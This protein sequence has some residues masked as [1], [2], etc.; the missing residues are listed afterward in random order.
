[1]ADTDIRRQRSRELLIDALLE[2]METNH[3]GDITVSQVA[4]KA[5]V[6][7]STFYAQFSDMKVFVASITDGVLVQLR[8][9]TNPVEK[10]LKYGDDTSSKYFV[11]YFEFIAEHK[12]FFS[13]MLGPNGSPSFR[14]K[15]VDSAVLVYESVFRYVPTERMP[16]ERDILINYIANA[17]VGIT[18]QWLR[19]GMRLSADYMARSLTTIIFSGMLGGLGMDEL[20]TLPS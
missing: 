3:L 17:N 1:M 20:V 9:A 6:A 7:R 18:I 2:L 5:R 19:E 11:R 10:W 13:A 4:G 8:E 15:M 16:V 14:D 12:R